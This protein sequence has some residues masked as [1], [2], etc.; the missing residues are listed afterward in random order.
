MQ[1]QTLAVATSGPA[2]QACTIDQKAIALGGDRVLRCRG[3]PFAVEFP[4][5][6]ITQEKVGP[7]TSFLVNLDPG[8]VILGV[9]PATFEPIVFKDPKAGLDRSLDL[10]MGLLAQWKPRIERRYDVRLE[11]AIHGRGLEFSYPLGG[12]VVAGTVRAFLARGWIGI[13]LAGGP[14]DSKVHRGTEQANRFLDSLR[15]VPVD[16]GPYQAT[17]E[18]GARVT[19]PAD[20]WLNTDDRSKAAQGRPRERM[21]ALPDRDALFM[22]QEQELGNRRCADVI[23]QQSSRAFLE[24]HLRTTAEVQ[25][26]TLQRVT[27]AGTTALTVE[28]GVRSTADATSNVPHYP[29]VAVLFCKEPTFVLAVVMGNRAHGELRK[30]LE[31]IL[32]TYDR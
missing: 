3:I 22:L 4:T 29:A 28:A 7:G 21:Y 13:V 10:I 16:H 25:F 18:S 24:Q 26:K 17:L 5:T 6:N 2:P 14:N 32:N 27:I 19:L 15:V 8:I 1:S 20:A 30:A 23:D 11:G 31:G 12:K 9:R